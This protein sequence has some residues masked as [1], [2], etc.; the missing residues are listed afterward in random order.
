MLSMWG[1]WSCCHSSESHMIIT[2]PPVGY[3]APWARKCKPLHVCTHV[4]ELVMRARREKYKQKLILAWYQSGNQQGNRELQ[5]YHFTVFYWL[6]NTWCINDSHTVQK[7]SSSWVY[8]C[9]CVLISL[10]SSSVRASVCVMLNITGLYQW[11]Q[12]I[13]E[14]VSPK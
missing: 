4:V 8:T 3:T 2:T 6:T 9:W 12:W 10:F 5:F 7:N 14:V 13:P 11:V 1:R